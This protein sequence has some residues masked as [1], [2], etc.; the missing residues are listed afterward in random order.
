MLILNWIWLNKKSQMKAS[1][2]FTQCRNKCSYKGLFMWMT[3]IMN[4]FFLFIYYISLRST[5]YFIISLSSFAHWKLRCQMER[6]ERFYV[7]LQ[8]SCSR[9]SKS[10]TRTRRRSRWSWPALVQPS[11]P[12]TFSTDK[13]VRTNKSNHRVFHDKQIWQIWQK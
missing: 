10:C 8:I 4:V 11:E 5:T 9:G 7:K 3:E 6:F 12:S 1:H 2:T 13:S